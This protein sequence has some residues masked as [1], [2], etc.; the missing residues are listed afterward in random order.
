M[1]GGI[2]ISVVFVLK[3]VIYCLHE[4]APG[5]FEIPEILYFAIAST[6]FCYLER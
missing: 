4:E 3:L 5:F 1:L 2:L 6:A